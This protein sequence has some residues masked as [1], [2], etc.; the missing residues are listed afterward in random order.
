LQYFASDPLDQA[1]LFESVFRLTCHNRSR[2]WAER[3]ACAP[4]F[5][6]ALSLLKADGLVSEKPHPLKEFRRYYLTEK[7][8]QLA[9]RLEIEAR[10]RP[11][12]DEH[13]RELIPG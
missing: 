12:V 3:E 6:D 1:R 8:D 11:R 9:K 2:T 10:K 7:G 4:E 13:S 5:F